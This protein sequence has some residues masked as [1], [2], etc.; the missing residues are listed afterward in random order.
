M[1][2]WLWQW[3]FWWPRYSYQ[4]V[5]GRSFVSAEEAERNALVQAQGTGWE[6]IG[7]AAS[8]MCCAAI[9]HGGPPPGQRPE[10]DVYLLLR[11]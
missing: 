10:W 1:L 8:A 7:I 6:I 9:E 4:I 2:W 5:V 3:V 11:K